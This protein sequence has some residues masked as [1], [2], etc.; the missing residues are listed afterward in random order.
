[1]GLG[2]HCA[3]VLDRTKVMV[4]QS[5]VKRGISIRSPGEVDIRCSG[6]IYALDMVNMFFPSSLPDAADVP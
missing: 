1:M 3:P 5:Q 6:E 4:Q 2:Y